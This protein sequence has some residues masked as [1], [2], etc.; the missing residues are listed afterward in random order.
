MRKVIPVD[1]AQ[2]FALVEFVNKNKW[3]NDEVVCT[4]TYPQGSTY[5]FCDEADGESFWMI[6]NNK[7]FTGSLEACIGHVV[8]NAPRVPEPRKKK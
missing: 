8:L 3:G 4:I 1:G 7:S 5:I 6:C 2:T